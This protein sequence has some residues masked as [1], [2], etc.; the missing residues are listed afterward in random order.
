MNMDS[1]G[2]CWTKDGY[3]KRGYNNHFLQ[4]CFKISISGHKISSWP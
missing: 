4:F 1:S 3:A 2:H